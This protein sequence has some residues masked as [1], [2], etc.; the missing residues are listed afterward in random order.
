[1]IIKKKSIL[2]KRSKKKKMC[3]FFPHLPDPPLKCG[4]TFWGQKFFLHFYP[5][6]D[7]PTHKNWMK[8]DKIL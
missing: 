4:N 7:L 2:G 6:N 1:M 5:E 8:W 3:G